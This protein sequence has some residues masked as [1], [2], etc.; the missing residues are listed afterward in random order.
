MSTPPVIMTAPSA[1]QLE[2]PVHWVTSDDQLAE[3]CERW[4]KLPMLAVDTE[5]M[6][7]Q[8]Y[9]P[10]PALV[11]VN[12][13]SGNYLIDPL[14]IEDFT[15]LREVLL[16][17]GVAK[18]LHS[19]SEDL[20]VFQTLLGAIPHNIF[21]TQVAAAMS[22][23]GFS[24]GY[25]NLVGQVLNVDLPKAETRSDWLQRPLS[26]AQVL[27]AAIDVEYLLVVAEKLREQ[28]EASG[29]LSWLEEDSER[30]V[31]QLAGAQDADTFYLR[32]KSAWRLKPVEL[33]VLKALAT[34]REAVAQA[35]NVPRNRVLKEHLLVTFAQQKP[36]HVGQLRKYEGI[37]ERMIRADGATIIQLIQ[38][39]LASDPA[40]WPQSLPKPLPPALTSL[41]KCLK[42][43]V[44]K[45]ADELQLAPEC[46]L[47]KKDYEQLVRLAAAAAK[48]GNDLAW[49][50]TLRG[51]RE[52]VLKEPVLEVLTP[53]REAASEDLV[54]VEEQ[55]I[56]E[57]QSTV[58][59]DAP[60]PQ[61]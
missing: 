2:H 4:Q 57:G 1:P 23:Y 58:D 18:V 27:Y 17:Q 19:C 56:G 31:S 26:Q 37:T 3:L 9:Y 55:E 6:R 29:R 5:F 59:S 43:R 34:W 7:S 8:T 35:R 53:K 46:L 41:M 16:D 28:L 33:A 12:D 50:D 24:M 11:Q 30:L 25:A 60:G 54:S 45:L 14:K 40:T 52:A 32:V 36:E 21:D 49:P 20:E 48:A 47:R 10:K 13:G 44:Q 61:D 15:P 39:A 38:D 42:A 51:W 22:G